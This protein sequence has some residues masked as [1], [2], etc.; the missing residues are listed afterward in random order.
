MVAQT[1]A[2]FIIE[3]WNGLRCIWSKIT[4]LTDGL[5]MEVMEKIVSI[6]YKRIDVRNREGRKRF[7]CF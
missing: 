2:C 5:V 1:W 6:G 4:G 7:S 3:N